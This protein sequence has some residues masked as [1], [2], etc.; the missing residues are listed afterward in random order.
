M[1]K[2]NVKITEIEGKIK[3][4]LCKSKRTKKEEEELKSLRNTR[5]ARLQRMKKR[6][7]KVDDKE[8]PCK[9]ESIIQ[10]LEVM[11]VDKI[12]RKVIA[13]NDTRGNRRGRAPA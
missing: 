12:T 10:V 1:Q 3:K 9:L 4:L 5:S 11:K 2:S 6:Q 8:L 7:V 13:K